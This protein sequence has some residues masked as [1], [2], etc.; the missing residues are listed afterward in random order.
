MVKS[1]EFER[2]LFIFSW[3]KNPSQGVFSD[4]QAKNKDSDTPHLT[5]L[6]MN[7]WTLSSEI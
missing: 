1:F 2:Y 3:W 5:S 4:A 7:F 6:A